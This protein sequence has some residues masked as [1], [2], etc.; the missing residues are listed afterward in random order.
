[1]RALTFMMLLAGA[2]SAA[3]KPVNLV[4]EDQFEKLPDI[5][6]QK[7]AVL[8]LVYGDSKAVTECR[9][10]GENLHLA[11]HP[12]AKGLE[13][14]KARQQPV[15]ALP[16][17]PAG[18]TSPAVTVQAVACCGKMPT[19]AR[20]LL[21]EQLKKASPELPIWLDFN[22]TMVQHFGMTTGQVNVAVFDVEGRF[23][24]VVNGTQD[25]KQQ[26]ELVDTIQALR[27]EAVK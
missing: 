3:E 22:T 26:V 6:S 19:I 24:K 11:F 2:A 16:N 14:V 9:T 1:M 23:R 17:L 18:K 10:W 7:G 27:T 8:V 20:P 21:R 15:A 25:A 12:G 5:A 13:P 4:F